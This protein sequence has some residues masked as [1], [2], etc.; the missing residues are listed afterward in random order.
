MAKTTTPGAV[1][2][3]AAAAPTA[4]AYTIEGL[5]KSSRMPILFNGQEYDLAN[6]RPEDVV[7]LLGFP[8]QV[9]YLKAATPAVIND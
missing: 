9:P 2:T 7:Y 6:L 1:A 4:P 8:D 5:E 3:E